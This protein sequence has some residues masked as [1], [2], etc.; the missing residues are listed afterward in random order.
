MGSKIVQFTIKETKAEVWA[1]N[2][3]LKGPGPLWWIGPQI[4]LM[5]WDAPFFQ[6]LIFIE[7]DTQIC[8]RGTVK[9]RISLVDRPCSQRPKKT[10][11]QGCHRLGEAWSIST[12]YVVIRWSLAHVEQEIIIQRYKN[13]LGDFPKHQG[14]PLCWVG[15]WNLSKTGWRYLC[16]HCCGCSSE[17]HNLVQK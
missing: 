3:L 2:H 9:Y 10:N 16:Q 8:K 12:D 14:I 7:A 6:D 1:N 13:K 5:I 15:T 11:K 17:P 4:F